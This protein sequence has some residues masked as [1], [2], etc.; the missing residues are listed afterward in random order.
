MYILHNLKQYSMNKGLLFIIL[1]IICATA[2]IV[3]WQIGSNSGHL[4]EL[5]DYF[6]VPL[7]LAGILLIVGI[8]KMNK[9]Q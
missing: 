9:K 4:T 7:P 1:G 8:Q 3:M 6:Y 5:K 2:S